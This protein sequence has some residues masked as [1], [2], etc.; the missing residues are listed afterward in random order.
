MAS[1]NFSLVLYHYIE[2]HYP[3]TFNSDY[4]KG[5]VKHLLENQNKILVNAG[6]EISCLLR[7]L[8]WPKYSATSTG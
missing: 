5:Q 8:A 4:L 3:S 1:S 2:E 7:V 6:R